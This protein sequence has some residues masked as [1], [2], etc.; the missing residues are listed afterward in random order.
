MKYVGEPLVGG[1]FATMSGTYS[2][3]LLPTTMRQIARLS[4]RR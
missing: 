4:V 2:R 3:P 1:G